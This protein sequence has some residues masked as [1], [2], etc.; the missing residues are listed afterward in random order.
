MIPAAVRRGHYD[1]QPAEPLDPDS[2]PFEPV[3]RDG[4]RGVDDDMDSLLKGRH[5]RDG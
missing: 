3:V 5:S 4:R 1:V 2:N